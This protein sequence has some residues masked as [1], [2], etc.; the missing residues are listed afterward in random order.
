MKTT[1]PDWLT[2][3]P[4]SPGPRDQ[5]RPEGREPLA[6][7]QVQPG[8]LGARPAPA[9]IS[10][11]E[12]AAVG[13]PSEPGGLGGMVTAPVLHP[14]LT[15]QALV[16]VVQLLPLAEVLLL[17]LGHQVLRLR[18]LLQ[19]LGGNAGRLSGGWSRRG[20]VL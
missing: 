19:E 7:P 13:S 1:N 18:Q 6:G 15:L 4:W 16:D 3:S 9:Q 11:V 12:A 5:P 2:D 10:P 8:V 17:Q 14:R 20:G